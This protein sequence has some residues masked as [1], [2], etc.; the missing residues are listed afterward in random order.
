MLPVEMLLNYSQ[1]KLKVPL[2]IGK[3]LDISVNKQG[4]LQTVV[5]SAS[6]SC[7]T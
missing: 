3:R 6:M 1:L 5:N 7:A 4:L 2:A